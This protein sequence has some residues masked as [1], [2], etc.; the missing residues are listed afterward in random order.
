MEWQR[1]GPEL[2]EKQL[3]TVVDLA[4]FTL[5][6]L[7]VSRV[8]APSEMISRKGSRPGRRAA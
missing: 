4:A 8:V 2:I 1:V 6:C 3:L 7:N 5:Y